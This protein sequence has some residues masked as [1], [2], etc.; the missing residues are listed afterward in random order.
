MDHCTKKSKIMDAVF[1]TALD[2]YMLDLM[3]E[4]RIDEFHQLCYER[5]DQEKIHSAV[6]GETDW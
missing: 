1:E 2:L 4:D 3:D 6:D 5:N